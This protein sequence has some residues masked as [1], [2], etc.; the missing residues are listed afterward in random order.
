MDLENEKGTD[1]DCDLSLT[2]G[3]RPHEEGSSKQAVNTVNVATESAH[4]G[5]KDGPF[6]II[7][8][9]VDIVHQGSPSLKS[10]PFL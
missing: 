5:K 9:L 2:G 7:V 3:H 4:N 6:T 1:G 10:A 8:N